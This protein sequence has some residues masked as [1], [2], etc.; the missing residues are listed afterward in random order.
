MK[1]TINLNMEVNF[2]SCEVTPHCYKCSVTSFFANF[3]GKNDQ[4][5]HLPFS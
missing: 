2:R 5:C 4:F 3:V 1:L